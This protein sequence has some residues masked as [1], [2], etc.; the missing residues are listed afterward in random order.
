MPSTYTV[1]NKTTFSMLLGLTLVV[2]VF[3]A[4]G[5]TRTWDPGNQPTASTSSSGI[6]RRIVLFAPVDASM[7]AA[8]YPAAPLELARSMARRADLLTSNVESWVGETLPNSSNSRWNAGPLGAA[9]GA[10]NVVLTQVVDIERSRPIGP[11]PGRITATVAMRVLDAAGNQV[12]AN[13]FRGFADDVSS[14]RQVSDASNPVSK[15]VWD[16]CDTGIWGL[17]RWFDAVGAPGSPRPD[18][19]APVAGDVALIDVTIS[20]IPEH[21]DI[22][23]DDIFRGTTPAVVPLP[24]QMMTVRIERAG[25]TPWQR[26]VR[27]SPDMRIQPALLP[28]I[29]GDGNALPLPSEPAGS[30]RVDSDPA[31]VTVPERRPAPPIV[32]PP[33]ERA[34]E[35]GPAR[36]PVE[37][38]RGVDLPPVE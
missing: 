20:S 29:G 37:E 33:A 5:G 12:W 21:A 7:I 25:F 28:L 10:H 31:A 18:F 2:S 13:E 4:C 32:E 8:D 26:E 3:T 38:L 34:P 15:A 6:V 19:S 23:V 16:A 24:V 17:R 36:D 35:A 1:M 9:S 11:R 14:T 27:P 30:S 22:F